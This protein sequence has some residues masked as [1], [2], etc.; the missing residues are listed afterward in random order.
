LKTPIDPKTP[1]LG[2]K[3]NQVVFMPGRI[4]HG[5]KELTDRFFRD[6]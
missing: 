5:K 6:S 1:E 2:P 4:E 3:A